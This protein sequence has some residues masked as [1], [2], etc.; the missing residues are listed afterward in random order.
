MDKQFCP[1]CKKKISGNKMKCSNC[2]LVIPLKTRTRI[3]RTKAIGMAAVAIIFI[4]LVIYVYLPEYVKPY[5]SNEPPEII[6]AETL[7][8]I[9]G[10][11]FTSSDVVAKFNTFLKDEGAGA[12]SISHLVLKSGETEDIYREIKDDISISIVTPKGHDAVTSVYVSAQR[13]NEK[14]F[15]TYCYGLLSIFTPTMKPDVRQRV[16]YAM[17]EYNENVDMPLRDENT[18]IIVETKYTFTYSQQKEMRMLVEQMPALE[19]AHPGSIPP[20]IR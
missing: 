4:I 18:Y 6:N 19:E 5:T 12:L 1:S 2:G 7:K 9:S 10:A 15:M 17:M 8:D 16:L 11:E 20:M 3:T 14:E 13:S